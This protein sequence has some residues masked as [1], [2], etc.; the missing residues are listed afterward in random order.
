MNSTKGFIL[1]VVLIFLQL[2]SLLSLWGMMDIAQVAKKNYHQWQGDHYLLIAY[3]LMSQ[4]AQTTNIPLCMIP[5]SSIIHL[6]KQSH[7]WWKQHAC[8]NIF[9]DVPYFYVVESLGQDECS[10]AKNA[11]NQPVVVTYYRL[12][13]LIMPIRFK[14]SKIMLQSTITNLTDQIS[15][16]QKEKHWVKLGIQMCRQI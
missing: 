1:F 11:S 14:H 12:T 7:T 6:E 8:R 10:V 9:N 15:T 4:L 16:C 5:L 13:L 2:F 3:H